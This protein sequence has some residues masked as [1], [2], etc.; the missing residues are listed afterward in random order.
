MSKTM[1]KIGIETTNSAT[2]TI[3]GIAGFKPVR[4]DDDAWYYV[5][6]V[7]KSKCMVFVNDN[8]V[9]IHNVI[10]YGSINR[11]QGHGTRMIADIRQAFPNHHIWV[12]SANCAR[13]FWEKMV[14]RGIIDSIE[15]EYSWPCFDTNCMT[16]H[17]N[18]VTGKRRDVSW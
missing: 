5:G 8:C 14:H 7:P 17:P 3:N 13:G 4:H 1:K 6:R 2:Q 10:V 12:N 9:E 18:R 11:N 16:C 15:N